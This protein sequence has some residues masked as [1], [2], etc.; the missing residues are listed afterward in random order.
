MRFILILI[1]LSLVLITSGCVRETGEII[2]I[3]E[4]NVTDN[5]TEAGLDEEPPENITE[6]EEEEVPEEVNITEN[7]TEE[8]A[9]DLC[10]SVICDDSI[11]T[12][13]DG[14]PVTCENTCEPE[15]GN[16]TA[17]VPDCTGHEAVEEICTLECERCQI[18]DEED[19]LCT[20]ELYCDGNGICEPIVGEW[21]DG[22]DCIVFD[23][24]DDKDDCT[25]DVFNPNLQE[26]A[27]FDICCDDGIACTVDTFNEETKECEHS[28]CCGNDICDEEVGETEENCPDDCFV[29][30]VEPG[31]VNITHINETE[32]IVTLEGFG[33]DMTGWTLEDAANHEYT[34]PDDFVIDGLVYLHTFGN[35]TD[36]NET[37]LFWG[38]GSAVWNNEGDTATLKDSGETVAST[39]EY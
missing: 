19:C 7:V 3:T 20:T 9:I 18:L 11:T 25:R 15:T 32:E 30:G 2:N 24:C 26:C 37:D 6:S 38:M 33:I 16:C 12:C 10:A 14:E 36:S 35:E 5:I 4:P 34:F 13:P 8:E 28:S 23:E 31:D 39:Y 27:H 17:C 1:I 29:A 22:D 21:P